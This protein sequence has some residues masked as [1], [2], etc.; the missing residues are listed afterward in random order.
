M[1]ITP[2]N[3]LIH[4]L[5]SQGGRLIFV[6]GF[7][8]DMCM[9]ID[10]K[11][12]DAEVYGLTAEALESILQDFGPVHKI[13]KSFGVYKL[14]TPE[15]E[16]ALPRIDN[17]VRP[18]HAGFEVTVDPFMDFEMAVKRRDLTINSIGYDPLT[19]DILDPYHGQ[20]DIKDLI[21]RP[22]DPKTFP[23]DP[24]RVLRVAQFSARFNMDISPILYD[25][26]RQIDLFE[27]P[28]A[29]I[30]TEL[31]KILTKGKTPSKAF[32]FLRK[33]HK[34]HVFPE[35]EA[36]IDVPQNPLWHPEGDVWIH[37]M[38]V[39][40]YAAQNPPTHEH[41]WT[42]LMCAALC[43]DF[44]KVL[45]TKILPDG[46]TTAR[47]HEN[48]GAKPARAFLR[49]L[50]VHHKIIKQVQLLTKLHL[51]PQQAFIKKPNHAYYLH[52]GRQLHDQ[53]LTID[54][55]AWLSRVDHMGR[56][57]QEALDNACPAIDF[58]EDAAATAGATDVSN[59]IDV[60]TGKDLIAMG[61]TPGQYFQDILATCRDIQFRQ[62]LK[63][64]KKIL[65]QVL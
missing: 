42:M 53:G 65:R 39:L 55:L 32:N 33:S 47:G 61:L 20:K 5:Q 19:K 40:D 24:L 26:C 10:A 48:S 3:Q 21:L 59:L 18:G 50:G 6:G 4:A 45:S 64:P 31:V 29:R 51:V 28:A 37:T 46:R 62:N 13:G 25:L 2:F 8:R 52:L 30:K 34:I 60:V 23:E 38:M 63:D 54:D 12:I 58:F 17:K 49:R 1:D 57:T 35:I 7:V 14:N 16:I 56:T 15:I 44:G 27:L 43:H 41:N 9:G 36:L 11:D 22:V